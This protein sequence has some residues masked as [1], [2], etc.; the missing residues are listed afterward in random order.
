MADATPTAL[1]P[2]TGLAALLALLAGRA[3]PLAPLRGVTALLAPPLCWS[4]RGR[5]RAREPLCLACRGSLRPLGAP[6]SELAGVRSWAAVAYEGAARDLVRA[7]KYRGAVAVA[8][9]MAAQIVA[10]APA[11]LLRGG[12]LVPVPLHPARRRRRGFNQ[13]ELLA[14]AIGR[15][16]GLPAA[17]CL[18]RVG[19]ERGTQVGRGRDE[20]LESLRGQIRP[21]TDDA[22][23]TVAVLVDDVATTGATLAACAA[24]LHAHGTGHVV[25]LTYARTLGR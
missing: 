23:P 22:R 1:A 19:P 18:R 5:A 7:L 16:G 24:A 4:C 21:I 14:R 15:R 2:L 20:R 3:A 9:T 6:P 13:A 25:A 8:D 17:T 12:V 10:R 11:E